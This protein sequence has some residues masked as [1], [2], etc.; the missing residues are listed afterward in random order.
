MFGHTS[1]IDDSV[2][3]PVLAPVRSCPAYMGTPK[4][5]L[6]AVGRL[7]SVIT[8][9]VRT[10]E[11]LPTSGGVVGVETGLL[12]RSG[13]LSGQRAWG[14][15]SRPPAGVSPS[16]SRFA[17]PPPASPPRGATPNRLVGFRLGSIRKSGTVLTR[18][19]EGWPQCGH[20][21]F[22]TLAYD[23]AAVLRD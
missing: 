12:A 20:P 16:A 1:V 3:L 5:H 10:A 8:R 15:G 22:T 11:S 13:A 6:D 2:A 7:S 19:K 18:V 23:H 21:S 4:E 17:P 14:G 9:M